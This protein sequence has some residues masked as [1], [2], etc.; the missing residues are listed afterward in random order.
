MADF[1][2]LRLNRVV[3]NRMTVHV[4]PR[5]SSRNTYLSHL[6]YPGSNGYRLLE[7]VVLLL[8]SLYPDLSNDQS[9]HRF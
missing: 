8:Q 5:S 6:L 4:A 3:H 7:L 1:A 2:P 9:L